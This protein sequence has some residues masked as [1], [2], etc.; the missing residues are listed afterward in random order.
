MKMLVRIKKW[1]IS[2]IRS[3]FRK[4]LQKSDYDELSIRNDE[5]KDKLNY[6]IMESQQYY[7]NMLR[8]SL[9]GLNYGYD[10]PENGKS[11]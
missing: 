7:H 6:G 10:N 3:W 5:R 9:K 8:E 4:V 1:I 2:V 11:I